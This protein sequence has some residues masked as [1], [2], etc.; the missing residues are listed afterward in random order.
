MQRQAQKRLS[1]AKKRTEQ[2]SITSRSEP[3]SDYAKEVKDRITSG[4][5]YEQATSGASERRDVTSR[6]S[7]G[8]P[9]F[10]EKAADPAVLAAQEQRAQERAIQDQQAAQD[11]LVEAQ[12][13]GNIASLRGA[14]TTALGATQRQRER[15]GEEAFAQRRGLR[16]TGEQ[17]KRSLSEYLATRGLGRSGAAAQGTIAQNVQLQEGIGA[18]RA[19]EAGALTDIGQRETDIRTQTA[20]GIA[21][22]GQQAEAQR[23]QLEIA[24]IQ[25]EAE[26]QRQVQQLAAQ[27]QFEEQEYQR[28][29]ATSLNAEQRQQDFQRELIGLEEEIR[30]AREGRDNVREDQLLQRK[31]EL[32]RGLIQLRSSLSGSGGSRG[33]TFSQTRQQFND[34]VDSYKQGIDSIIARGDLEG[35]NQDPVIIKYLRDLREQGEDPEVIAELARQIGASGIII[36]QASLGGINI[37]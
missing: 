4:Q 26:Q 2:K 27:R 25:Q 16:T 13:Q 11:R 12:R 28:N 20:S 31:N 15:T 36:P 8:A 32:E 10:G 18:S 1:D 21:Q 19:Q 22:A 37:R 30:I 6:T 3:L 34:K 35:T 7:E 17:A 29:L 14:E 9:I 23:A 24:R 33:L 5:S